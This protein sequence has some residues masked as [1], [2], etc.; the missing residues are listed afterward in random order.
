MTSEYPCGRDT[1]AQNVKLT[2]STF[3]S[4]STFVGLQIYRVSVKIVAHWT[5]KKWMSSQNDKFQ[6]GS[7]PVNNLYVLEGRGGRPADDLV[8]DVS[9]FKGSL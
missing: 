9:S 8:L 3:K 5:S 2:S 7:R 4:R 6:P 1:L